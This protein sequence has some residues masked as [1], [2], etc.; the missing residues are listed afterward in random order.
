MAR[1]MRRIGTGMAVLAVL[2]ILIGGVGGGLLLTHLLTPGQVDWSGASQPAPRAPLAIN[3]R[4]DPRDGLGLD[5]STIHFMTDL[6]PAEA[7]LVPAYAPARTWAIYI[8]G[9]GGIRENGYKQLTILHDAGFPTLLITYRDDAGAPAGQPPFYSFGLSEWRDLDSA[10][11]WA[12]ANGANRIVLVADSMGGAVVGQFLRHSDKTG[13][14]VAL[15]FDSP[16][17]D[18]GDVTAGQFGRFHLPFTPVLNWIAL[19]VV[20]IEGRAPFSDTDTVAEVAAFAGPIF[21]A[22]GSADGLVPFAVS[23]RLLQ[24]RQGKGDITFLETSVD[25]LR[26]FEADP[27]RYRA[28]FSGFLAALPKG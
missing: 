19:Q 17:L 28:A 22:H 6:G 11:A 7:W 5:F 9:V 27:V 24:Q 3:F 1:W 23:Q 12:L 15:A 8:H 14:I 18:F 10:V 4:G 13:K 2:Y 16:A 21:L 26:S 20:S 25:H